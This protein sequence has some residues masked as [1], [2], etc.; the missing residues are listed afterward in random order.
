MKIRCTDCSKKISIDDAFAGGVCRCPYCST[1][2][3]VPVVFSL[4]HA[5]RGKRASAVFGES[6]VA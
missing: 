5:R 1:L 6:H 4:V 2:V 3:F